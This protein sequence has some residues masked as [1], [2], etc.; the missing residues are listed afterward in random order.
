MKL[1]SWG[2]TDVGQRRSH[3]EDYFLI[4]DE[5]NLFLVADGMGGLERGDMASR[6]SCEVV[7]DYVRRERAV[8][9]TFKEDRSPASRDALLKMLELAVQQACHEVYSVSERTQGRGMGTTLEVLVL[10]AGIG[11]LAHVGDSRI[12]LFR[13]G[14]VHQLT[15][16]HSLVQEK[17]RQGL[18]TREEARTARRRNVITRA[19]GVLP[20]VKVDTLSFEVDQGDAFLLCSDG[21]HQYFQDKEM[22]EA[23]NGVERDEVAGT[24]VEM[25]NKA[26]GSDNITALFI[27][28]ATS[29]P[30]EFWDKSSVKMETLAQTALFRF[31]NYRELVAVSGIAE[32]HSAPTGE[33]LF[34]EGEDGDCLY[35]ILSGRVSIIKNNAVLLTLEPGDHFG[36]MALLDRPLRSAHAVVER[37]AAFL[38][39]RRDVFY[40]LMKRNSILAVKLLWN[41]S[42]SLS[43]NLR[44]T[45]E[46]L[47][48]DGGVELP[49][50]PDYLNAYLNEQ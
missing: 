49:Q 50:V 43:A 21:L 48:T 23:V 17:V 29:I 13:G 12:F 40:T 16:D 32:Y 5:L 24:L 1:R 19:V 42:L 33:V 6:L 8:I 39:I 3:N 35:L 47:V 18:L 38:L 4:D 31:L 10:G 34:R 30:R 7:R 27:E 45:S 9:D 14:K 2:V 41:M 22:Q 36:E 46:Q 15:E 28:V 20:N 25:S 44:V 26:G 37:E 11:F